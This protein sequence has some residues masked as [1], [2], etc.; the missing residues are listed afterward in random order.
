M[1][2]WRVLTL[3]KEHGQQDRTERCVKTFSTQIKILC[4][5]VPGSFSQHCAIQFSKRIVYFLHQLFYKCYQHRQMISPFRK[6]STSA[7]LHRFPSQAE[8]R[9]SCRFPR[10]QF[11]TR[12]CW[13]P[14][15]PP[16]R[17]NP[18]LMLKLKKH[19][20]PQS[21]DFSLTWCH[22]E[23][24]DVLRS[25]CPLP[26]KNAGSPLRPARILVNQQSLGSSL[27]FRSCQL[28][29]LDRFSTMTRCSVRTGGPYLSL[30]E[31]LQLL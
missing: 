22:S 24:R 19:R 2:R 31:R 16:T 17:S 12:R 10:Q 15:P 28:H 5:K 1:N 30:P 18:Q 25:A 11:A 26:K 23:S 3:E 8:I 29:R 9:G 14:P 27:T 20:K 4:I 7:R 6:T 13:P 21:P